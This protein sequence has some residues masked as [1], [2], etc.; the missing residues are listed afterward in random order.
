MRSCLEDVSEN[1]MK[2]ICG[3]SRW[4]REATP[5]QLAL[6]HQRPERLSDSSKD[7]RLSARGERGRAERAAERVGTRGGLR[8]AGVAARMPT[9]GWG[10]PQ[11]FPG[12]IAQHTFHFPGGARSA[13]GRSRIPAYG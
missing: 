4:V 10:I 8:W 13:S 3:G 12:L 2:N 5:G 6:A 9:P 7:G 1:F 11:R